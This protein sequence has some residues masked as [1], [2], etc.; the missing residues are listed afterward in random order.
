MCRIS[1]IQRRRYAYICQS[2]ILRPRGKLAEEEQI[3]AAE[4]YSISLFMQVYVAMFAIFK[5]GSVI[6]LSMLSFQAQSRSMALLTFFSLFLFAIRTA[7]V[8]HFKFGR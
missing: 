7:H 5:F 8:R 6:I 4:A 3:K 1:P 2:S